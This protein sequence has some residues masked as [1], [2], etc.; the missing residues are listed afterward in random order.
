MR[1]FE[2]KK[3]PEPSLSAQ[4]YGNRVTGTVVGQ[5]VP[6]KD[7]SPA[8][9]FGDVRILQPP[10]HVRIDDE[11]LSYAL[12]QELQDF[13]DSD[14]FCCVGP[15]VLM[16]AAAIVAA[17]H[18]NGRIRFLEWDKKIRNYRKVRFDAQLNP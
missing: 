13:S 8:K 9:N 4:A 18:N 6:T 11:G 3:D 10:G 5:W 7:L 2:G 14:F 16:C 12:N 15:P 1:F 17:I